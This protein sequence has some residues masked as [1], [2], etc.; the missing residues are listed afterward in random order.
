MYIYDIHVYQLYTQMF[1]KVALNVSKV[2]C[3]YM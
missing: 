2:Y 3:M 1:T